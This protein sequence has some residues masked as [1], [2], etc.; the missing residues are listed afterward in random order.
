MLLG[1]K[2][3]ASGPT[4]ASFDR[5][6]LGHQKQIRRITEDLAGGKITV[7]EWSLRFD[8]ILAEGHT[9]GYVLGRQ[10]GGDLSP[11]SEADEAL[12]QIAKSA[13]QSFLANFRAD[14]GNHADS[15]YW[16]TD[17][18]LR[19]GPVLSRANLYTGKFRATAAEAFVSAGSEDDLYNWVLGGAEA[20][21]H[22]CPEM[23]ALSPYTAATLFSYPGGGDQPCLGNCKC[24][25][26]RLRDGKVAFG[27]LPR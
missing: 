5:M 16:D 15:R 2:K 24:H 6:V 9:R 13:D 27:P 25:L 1:F 11:R 19:V 26:V 21:C 7:F 23:A 10:H 8:S 20:H 14:L 4:Q 22:E 3:R 12:G 17:L 18:K